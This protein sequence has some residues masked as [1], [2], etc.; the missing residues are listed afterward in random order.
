[1]FPLSPMHCFLKIL[2]WIIADCLKVQGNNADVKSTVIYIF[3]FHET[4]RI[5]LP[6]EIR[7][8]SFTKGDNK[9]SPHC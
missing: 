9:K 2:L 8:G 7:T 5:T 3:F 6:V 1:M 4:G